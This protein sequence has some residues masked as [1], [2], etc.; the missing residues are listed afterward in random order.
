MKLKLSFG[1]IRTNRVEG[2]L[3]SSMSYIRLITEI[4]NQQK[5]E[6]TV[7]IVIIWKKLKLV[8]DTTKEEETFWI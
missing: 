1:E 6:I 3:K 5:D 2:K 8:E 7:K 4:V